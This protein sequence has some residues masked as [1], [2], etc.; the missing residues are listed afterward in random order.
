MR[1]AAAQSNDFI[2]FLLRFDNHHGSL[3]LT[4]YCPFWMINKTDLML[5]YRVSVSN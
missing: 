4:V 3:Q 5:S 1:A 2:F